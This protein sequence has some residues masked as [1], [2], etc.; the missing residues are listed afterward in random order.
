[1]KWS[2]RELLNRKENGYTHENYE[3]IQDVG[4]IL[5]EAPWA[6]VYK[7]MTNDANNILSGEYR[8]EHIINENEN[9]LFTAIWII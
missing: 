4:C 9:L 7:S 6:T 8:S 5:H 2:T 3:Q 1:M